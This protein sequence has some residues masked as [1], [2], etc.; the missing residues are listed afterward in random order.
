MLIKITKKVIAKLKNNYKSV[1]LIL[2]GLSFQ[3]ECFAT[4]ST[5]SSSIR[6]NFI[7]ILVDDLGYGDLGVYGNEIIHSPNIDKLAV[8]GM[9]FT[10]FYASAPMCSPSRAGLLTGRAPYRMGVYDWIAPNAEMH[11]PDSEQT[12]ATLLRDTGYATALSGKWH[13]NGVFN[14][15]AQPQPDDHGFDYWFGV[16]YSQPHLN[17]KDFYRNGKV[18]ETPG[19]AADI[20]ADD[21]IQWLSKTR[22]KNKPFFQFVNFLEP[23]EP[24]MSPPDLVNKYNKHGIK[25][26]YYANVENLDAAIG[27]IIK[28]VEEQGLDDNTLIIFTSDNGPAEYTPNGYFNKSH[29][30]AGP[31]KGYKRSMFEGGIRVPGIVRWNKH[32]MAGQISDQPISNVD[33]LPTLLSLAN[34]SIP[35][36]LKLD[37]SDISSVFTAKNIERLTPL[38]WHFYDPWGGPQSLL[39]QGDLMIGASWNTGDFHVRK[40]IYHPREKAII[41]DAKLIN[42]KLYDL[43]NDVHQDNDVA[44]LYPEKF[45]QMKSKLVA[46]HADVMA[47]SKTLNTKHND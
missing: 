21:A 29:A 17:P 43:S 1:A 5:E 18:V 6:P 7:V 40:A 41:D 27:R 31:F 12:V 2:I 44:K 47:D 14:T 22:D 34:V 23:H 37:G 38:H 13:L 30:S 45:E 26:E 24:I 3:T 36:D 25:A 32:I 19:Y 15:T 8:E 20:V 10:N 33:I 46:L 16:Q 9:K 28:T 11:L 39:R 4:P 42:F 35:S